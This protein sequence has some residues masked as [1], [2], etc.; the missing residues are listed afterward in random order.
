MSTGGAGRAERYAFTKSEVFVRPYEKR[1]NYA[2]EIA[3]SREVIHQNK[4][5]IE[6]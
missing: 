4:S 5:L 6:V 2:K 3:I 1:L